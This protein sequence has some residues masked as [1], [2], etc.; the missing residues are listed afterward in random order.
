MRS[1]AR[2][3]DPRE[4]IGELGGPSGGQLH[5]PRGRSAVAEIFFQRIRGWE[6]LGFCR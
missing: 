6:L 2:R 4:E 3:S 1:A 5:F